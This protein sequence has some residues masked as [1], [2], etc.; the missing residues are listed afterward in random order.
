M[1]DINLMS[2][3]LLRVEIQKKN[4]GV[5]EATR[6]YLERIEKYDQPSGLNTV[7]EINEAAIEQARRLDSAKT[8]QDSLLFGLPILVKDNIDVQGL[9]TTAGSL[10]LSDNIARNNAPVIENAVR[11]GAVILGKT[12]MTEFANYTSQSMPNGFSSRGVLCEA[13]MIEKKIPAGPAQVQQ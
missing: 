11:N 5:E 4:I 6:A 8:G 10:A 13:H 2:A 1:D 3:A 7:A 9:H 12:N